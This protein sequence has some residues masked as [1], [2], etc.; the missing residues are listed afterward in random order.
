MYIEKA[1]VLVLVV[2]YSRYVIK[3]LTEPDPSLEIGQ[4]LRFI[5]LLCFIIVISFCMD[6][7]AL[8][9]METWVD[10]VPV[11]QQNAHTRKHTHTP[12]WHAGCLGN[13]TSRKAGGAVTQ[14]VAG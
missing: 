6:T 13:Q 4:Q 9:S 14:L 1:I 7:D 11:I 8:V 2:K 5:I 10:C 12:L 3:S